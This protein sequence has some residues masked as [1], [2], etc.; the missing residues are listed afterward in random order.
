MLTSESHPQVHEHCPRLI[1]NKKRDPPNKILIW[2]HTEVK[3][4]G[5][6][7]D[8]VLHVERL[9]GIVWQE[10]ELRLYVDLLGIS[11]PPPCVEQVGSEKNIIDNSQ[12]YPSMSISSSSPPLNLLCPSP[13]VAARIIYNS[14]VLN[15]NPIRPVVHQLWWAD[16]VLKSDQ[17]G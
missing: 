9:M 11:S 15:I 2:L 16:Y 5:D 14:Y 3:D 13:W 6:P 8:F 7:A 1:V 12:T 10:N 17:V 4:L